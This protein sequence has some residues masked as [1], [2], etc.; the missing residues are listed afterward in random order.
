MVV[1]ETVPD[2]PTM[3][4]TDTVPETPMVPATANV[5]DIIAVIEVVGDKIIKPVSSTLGVICPVDVL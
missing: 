1:N 4:A 2:I 5:P 3:P